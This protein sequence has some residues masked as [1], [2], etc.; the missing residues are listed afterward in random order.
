MCGKFNER[1]KAHIDILLSGLVTRRGTTGKYMR[2]SL[3]E[4]NLGNGE[5]R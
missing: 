1:K 4:S 5:P 2:F 3:D